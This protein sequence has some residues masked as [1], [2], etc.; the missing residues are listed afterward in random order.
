[1]K[2]VEIEFWRKPHSC[3]RYGHHAGVRLEGDGLASLEEQVK[4][5]PKFSH[6]ILSTEARDA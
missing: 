1:L 5:C 6:V 4:D 2:I 3:V